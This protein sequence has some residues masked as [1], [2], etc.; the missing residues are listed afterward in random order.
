MATLQNKNT[1][2]V[3]KISNIGEKK[4]TIINKFTEQ[5][6]FSMKVEVKVMG[7]MTEKNAEYVF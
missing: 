5:L 2:G 7:G 4:F 6:K 3:S 1:T